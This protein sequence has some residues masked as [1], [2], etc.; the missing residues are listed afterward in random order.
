MA[1]TRP[2]TAAIRAGRLREA[3]N[4]LADAHALAALAADAPNNSYVSLLVLGGVAASDVVCCARLA[5]HSSGESHKEALAL[6]KQAGPELI[7]ALKTLLD[8]KIRIAYGHKPAS[9]VDRKRA[10]RAAAA[11]V[12]AARLL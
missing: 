1:R 4:H 3:E 6:L 5:K 9:A 10:L 7:P 11:L 8:M 2:C 12:E